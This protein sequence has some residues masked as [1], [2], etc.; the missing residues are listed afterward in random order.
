MI[1]NHF[2]HLLKFNIDIKKL[3]LEGF[4]LMF[5]FIY[6]HKR[7]HLFDQKYSKNTKYHLTW[8]L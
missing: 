4:V 8:N 2:Y 1:I 3:W 6:A 7:L 5:F